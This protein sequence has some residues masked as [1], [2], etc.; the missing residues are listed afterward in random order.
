MGEAKANEEVQIAS[1]STPDAERM[2]G[3]SMVS[4]FACLLPASV[5][6]WIKNI[7]AISGSLD[8]IQSE[9]DAKRRGILLGQAVAQTIG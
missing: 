9:A 3:V 8:L 2:H 1:A 5:G 7:Q 6:S 4:P